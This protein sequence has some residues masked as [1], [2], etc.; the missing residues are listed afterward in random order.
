METGDANRT[1]SAEAELWG[2]LRFC[3]FVF[4]KV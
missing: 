1:V 4:S 3:G 2:F